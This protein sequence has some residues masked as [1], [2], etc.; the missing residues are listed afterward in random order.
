[1]T[2]DISDGFNFAL[3]QWLGEFVIG[4]AGLAVVAIIGGMIYLGMRIHE[5]ISYR[6]MRR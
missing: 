3:G 2:L 5:R 4:L 1:M 6:R